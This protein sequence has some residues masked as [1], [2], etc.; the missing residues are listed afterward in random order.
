[1]ASTG[2]VAAFGYDLYS[3]YL[4]AMVSSG[5]KLPKKYILLSIGSYKVCVIVYIILDSL[6]CD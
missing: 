1:M 4:K 5:F 2:E 6:Y 3:A